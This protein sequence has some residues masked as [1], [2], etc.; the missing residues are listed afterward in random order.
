MRLKVLNFCR[1]IILFIIISTKID[2]H[3]NKEEKIIILKNKYVNIGEIPLMTEKGT[4]ILNGNTRIID[5]T[6]KIAGN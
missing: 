3:C 4:F 6:S 1:I 2:L 5:L